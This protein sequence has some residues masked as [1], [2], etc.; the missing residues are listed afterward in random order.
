MALEEQG[1]VT[2]SQEDSW[3]QV[4]NVTDLKF[5]KKFWD[6]TQSCELSRVT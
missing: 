4:M 3:T 5:Q 6:L 1:C 2:S